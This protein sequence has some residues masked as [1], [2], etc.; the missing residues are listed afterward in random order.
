MRDPELMIS[1]LKEM[2]KDDMGR[3]IIPMTFGMGERK[4]QRRH[5]VELLVDA[6]H[7]QWTGGKQD[8]ARITNAGYD[9]LNAMTN[10]THGKRVW[11]RF[12]ELFN[13]GVPYVRA[14]QTAC[15]FAA[16]AMGA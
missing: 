1:L 4:Q 3:L 6:G 14:A 13:S 2:S 5:H 9:F 11:S 16:K 10:P 7:A 12:V 8:I 15:E